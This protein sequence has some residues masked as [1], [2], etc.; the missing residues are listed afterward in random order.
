MVYEL[1]DI[2]K[3]DNGFI[4]SPSPYSSQAVI[5]PL[6]QRYPWPMSYLPNEMTEVE[7]FDHVSTQCC[8]LRNVL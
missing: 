4:L 3:E 1:P 5:M 8:N 6:L 2:S 7:L